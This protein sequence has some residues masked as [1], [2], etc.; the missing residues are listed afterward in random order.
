MPLHRGLESPRVVDVDVRLGL[1]VDRAEAKVDEVG[2]REGDVL[3]HGLHRDEEGTALRLDLHL[4]DVGLVLGGAEVDG[5]GLLHARR[6]LEGLGVRHVEL[7]GGRQLVLHLLRDERHVVQHQLAHALDS[8]LPFG[9]HHLVF[10][11]D[12]VQLHALVSRQLAVVAEVG[13]HCREQGASARRCAAVAARGM[14]RFRCSLSCGHLLH[15]R[16]LSNA[17]GPPHLGAGIRLGP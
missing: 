9:P 17:R 5:D 10:A 14:P 16:G 12:A 7:R 13:S 15:W 1:L 11:V 6:E 3:H 8:R 2:H 4:V